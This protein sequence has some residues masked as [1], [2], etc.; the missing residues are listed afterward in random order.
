MAYRVTAGAVTVEMD[1]PGGRARQ[2]LHRGAVLPADVPE[3]EVRELLGRGDVEI[4]EG[5]M[6]V[7][8]DSASPGDPVR[9]KR[10]R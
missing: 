5:D 8:T 9:P 3:A 1:I 10:K 4:V 7:S 2:D 6:Y